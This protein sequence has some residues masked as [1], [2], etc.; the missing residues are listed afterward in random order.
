MGSQ[1]ALTDPCR[2]HS[3]AAETGN[4]GTTLRDSLTADTPLREAPLCPGQDAHG[5]MWS[6]PRV[7]HCLLKLRQ[8]HQ[9]ASDHLNEDITILINLRLHPLGPKPKF[10]GAHLSQVLPTTFGRHWH[11][12]PLGSQ[13]ELNEPWGSH[14]QAAG[15]R[16]ARTCDT[17]QLLPPRNEGSLS[18][19][20]L[21]WPVPSFGLSLTLPTLLPRLIQKSHRKLSHP[22]GGN[23][24]QSWQIQAASLGRGYWGFPSLPPKLKYHRTLRQEPGDLWGLVGG[25]QFCAAPLIPSSW[26]FPLG[27]CCVF[28]EYWLYWQWC[29]ITEI[30]FKNK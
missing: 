19:L 21:N 2:W 26:T 20:A 28:L 9:Y 30:F 5:F 10:P 23:R 7:R 4:R 15:E 6:A 22:Y 8:P 29:S 14:S 13:T 17:E 1:K 25:F 24:R 18:H 12:P 3:Q 27:A 16:E 11:W